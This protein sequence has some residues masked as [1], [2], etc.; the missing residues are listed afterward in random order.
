MLARKIVLLASIPR[1]GRGSLEFVSAGRGVAAFSLPFT[2]T[3]MKVAIE[4]FD[5]CM[6]VTFE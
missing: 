2:A 4:S 3:G 1:L 5:I 6:E